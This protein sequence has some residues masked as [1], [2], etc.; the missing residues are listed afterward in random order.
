MYLLPT[1]YQALSVKSF[2]CL[3]SLTPPN[4]LI[5]WGLEIIS[6]YRGGNEVAKGLSNIPKVS[7]RAS[8]CWGQD[9]NPGR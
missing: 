2:T 8:K 7:Y 5:G 1:Q 3:V 4:S 6:L 9:L